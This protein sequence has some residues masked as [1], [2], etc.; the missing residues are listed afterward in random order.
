MKYC[1]IGGKSEGGTQD[2]TVAE[3]AMRRV[4][5]LKKELDH[6]DARL[7]AKMDDLYMDADARIS[8]LETAPCCQPVA[9]PVALPP[10]TPQVAAPQ[11]TQHTTTVIKETVDLSSINVQLQEQA[12]HIDQLDDDLAANETDI[13]ALIADNR[14]LRRYLLIGASVNAVLLV[15]SFIL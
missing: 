3:A 11:A 4:G 6:R 14:Q 8:A 2:N 15:L 1:N 12:D 13:A 7:N 10:Q 5:K 9:V